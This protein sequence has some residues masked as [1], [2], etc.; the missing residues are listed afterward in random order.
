MQRNRSETMA[1]SCNQMYE[2]SSHTHTQQIVA[3]HISSCL[4]LP[5]CCLAYARCVYNLYIPKSCF[6]Q[7]RNHEKIATATATDHLRP[8]KTLFHWKHAAQA[9]R[10]LYVV[11]AVE[12]IHMFHCIHSVRQ[13]V[14]LHSYDN[15]PNNGAFSVHI[16]HRARCSLF[17]PE[18]QSQWVAKLKNCINFI[19]QT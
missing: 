6:C 15:A 17:G 5:W 10:T 18:Q 9:H 13:I 4:V 8:L 19:G 7:K 11:H 2:I 12:R 14:G 3:E 1:S 16:V